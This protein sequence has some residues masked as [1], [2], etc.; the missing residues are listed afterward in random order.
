[1]VRREALNL[2]GPLDERFFMYKEDVDWCKRF[3]E[4]GWAIVFCPEASAI[5]YGGA[6]SS[7]APAR[8]MLEMENANVQYWKKHHSTAA[9]K[10][11]RVISW[12]HYGI[13]LLGWAM[14]YLVRQKSRVIASDMVRK[15][16]VCLSWLSGF[17]RGAFG[18]LS[19]Q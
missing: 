16:A 14:T 17:G 10:I 15:N 12:V 19:R 6:S 9:E 5:H 18:D 2:V 1:M 8:F 4:A 13:R 7:K 3:G 11:V